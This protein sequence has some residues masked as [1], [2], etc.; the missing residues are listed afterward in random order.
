LKVDATVNAADAAL[1]AFGVRARKPRLSS[2]PT[3]V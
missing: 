2:I 1:A 3:G